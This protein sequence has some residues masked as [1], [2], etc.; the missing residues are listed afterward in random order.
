MSPA[1]W[2]IGHQ[3]PERRPIRAVHRDL[4]PENIMI[5]QRDGANFCKL[6]DFGEENESLVHTQS[7]MVMGTEL[8]G[9]RADQGRS[10]ESSH[11]IYAR[12]GVL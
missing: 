6:L 9:S 2:P 12:W 7:G 5:I 11:H 10:R 3:S 8:H 1:T 4:K